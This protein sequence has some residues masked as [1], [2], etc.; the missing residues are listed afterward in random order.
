MTALEYRYR[1]YVNSSAAPTAS[2]RDGGEIRLSGSSSYLLSP[3][4]LLG[5]NGFVQRSEAERGF[6]AYVEGGLT[7]SISYSFASPLGEGYGPWTITPSAGFV[8]R[9]Y[10]DPDPVVNPF[11]AEQ[12]RELFVGANLIVPVNASW[13]VLAEAEYRDVSS[14]Y[15]MRDYDNASVSLSIVKRF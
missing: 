4:L 1:D 7:G 14:N 8:Y 10:D 9:T 13:S 5:V 11:A 6:L 3:R 12:D 15:A 2:L